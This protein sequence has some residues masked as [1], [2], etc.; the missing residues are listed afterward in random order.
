MAQSGAEQFAEE[1]GGKPVPVEPQDRYVHKGAFRM[2]SFQTAE[3]DSFQP[4]AEMRQK[5]DGPEELAHAFG[6]K[7]LQE[8]LQDLGT[9][10][11]RIGLDDVA[12]VV[13]LR[14]FTSW[15]GLR[16]PQRFA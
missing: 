8:C 4:R 5:I 3:E 14:A 16:A 6:F 10:R 2:S 15:D 9:S 12:G 13:A 7:L 11:I 1:A